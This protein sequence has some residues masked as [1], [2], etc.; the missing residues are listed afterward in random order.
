MNILIVEDELT[1]V[2][3]LDFYVRDFLSTN[4]IKQFN[5]D[6]AENGIEAVGYNLVNKYDLMLLDVRLPKLDGIK[7]LN[8]LKNNSS[9]NKPYICMTTSLGQ[10]KYKKLFKL[11]HANTYLIKPFNKEKTHEILLKIKNNLEEI[12]VKTIDETEVVDEFGE[13]IDIANNSHQHISAIEFL[14]D[15]EN[16]EYMLDDIE[17]IDDLITNLVI[18]LNADT[19]SSQQMDIDV[20]LTKYVIFLNSLVSF[21]ELSNALTMLKYEINSI[22]IK[23]YDELKVIYIIE[24]IRTILEDISDWKEYVFVEKSANDVYYINASI[25]SNCIQ[26]KNLIKE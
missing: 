24:L 3:L 6:Y 18:E 1:N 8:I 2:K 17:D 25:L 9:L 13:I 19:F 16:I 5:I 10:D 15:Y 21:E 22:D 11:L 7:V 14:K 4:N 23:K 12:D 26:L 20:S